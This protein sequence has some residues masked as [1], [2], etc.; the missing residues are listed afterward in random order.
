MSKPQEEKDVPEIVKKW[1]DENTA[2]FGDAER[3]FYRDNVLDRCKQFLFA[4]DDYLE[5]MLKT[6]PELM[7]WYHNV[8]QTV[9]MAGMAGLTV[10]IL[11]L[12][13]NNFF[14]WIQNLSFDLSIVR[15]FFPAGIL[16][17]IGILLLRIDK[18][19]GSPKISE[20]IQTHFRIKHNLKEIEIMMYYISTI[21]RIR[22]VN[23]LKKDG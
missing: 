10:T 1:I 13:L 18:T 9:F 20:L 11:V 6:L 19:L 17:V 8:F 3:K 2:E 5:A 16:V 15:W 4:P 23:K 22:E 14:E 7:K 12:F 21:L